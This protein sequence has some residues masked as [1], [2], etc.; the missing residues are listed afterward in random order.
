MSCKNVHF[1]VISLDKKAAT[2][3]T[4]SLV[5]KVCFNSVFINNIFGAMFEQV[6]LPAEE[7]GVPPLR[8]CHTMT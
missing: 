3:Q 6:N 7:L 5:L 8:P 2:G 4:T 1:I